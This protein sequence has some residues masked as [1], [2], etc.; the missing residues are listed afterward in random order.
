MFGKIQLKNLSH[1]CAYCGISL[2]N[3]AKTIDHIIP[4]VLEGKVI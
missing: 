2:K 3:E 1:I 4:H